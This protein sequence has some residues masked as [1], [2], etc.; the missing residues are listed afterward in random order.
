MTVVEPLEVGQKVNYDDYK[1]FVEFQ[2]DLRMKSSN[3][4]LRFSTTT[5]CAVRSPCDDPFSHI[6]FVAVE[7][8][9]QTPVHLTES[10]TCLTSVMEGL[11]T[12]S[13]P[14]HFSLVLDCVD[15]EQCD[16][17]SMVDSSVLLSKP[18]VANNHFRYSS[19]MSTLMYSMLE[20]SGSELLC[21]KYEDEPHLNSNREQENGVDIVL[22]T[23]FTTKKDPQRLN[24]IKPNNYNYVSAWDQ[25]LRKLGLRGIVFHDGLAP[26]FIKS[27]Q[28]KVNFEKVVLSKRLS[29]ND[30]RYVHYLRHIEKHPHIR[31]VLMT[32][33]A[34]VMFLRDPFK[35]MRV[36]G[37]HLYIGE[38]QQLTFIGSN[39]W[40]RAGFQNCFRNG[41]DLKGSKKWLNR[42]T[43]M[44]NA[45]VIGG[46]RHIVLRFLRIVTA[47]LET[48]PKETNCNMP[49]INYVVHKYF[50][51]V[52][53]TGFPL[54][55]RFLA[56]QFNPAGVVMIHK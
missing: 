26:N 23:Y 14:P 11:K 2:D 33:I 34:D 50:D 28:S 5:T 36:L 19:I 18:K 40:L 49:A 8:F 30:D 12:L 38:D 35:L 7:S 43:P 39:R 55:S 10:A 51:D 52:I 22:S 29:L 3:D 46:P 21:L 48:L 37:D 9:R 54:T 41:T 25:S 20:Q 53:F 6:F 32:D 42:V 47:I 45:G 44:Y 13:T 24:H 16:C 27:I 17:V 4:A 31:Y 1:R 56:H 15:D